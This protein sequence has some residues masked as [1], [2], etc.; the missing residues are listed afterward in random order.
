MDGKMLDGLSSITV[1]DE[2]VVHTVDDTKV[3]QRRLF[4]WMRRWWWTLRGR[5]LHRRN[6]KSSN[7]CDHNLAFVPE[8]DEIN[9]MVLYKNWP[10][11]FQKGQRSVRI[12]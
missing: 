11:Y 9:S 6:R 12:P 1:N 8:E 5:L 3:I 2:A 4:I 10:K 7:D